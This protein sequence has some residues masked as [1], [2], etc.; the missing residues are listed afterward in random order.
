MSYLPEIGCGDGTGRKQRVELARNGFPVG[1]GSGI[2][3]PAALF[4]NSHNLHVAAIN[5]GNTCVTNKRLVLRDGVNKTQEIGIGFKK[6]RLGLL[7]GEVATQGVGLILC[8]G[9]LATPAD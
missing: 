8:H 1:V 3:L 4:V 9:L 2:D 6:L 5:G 7:D